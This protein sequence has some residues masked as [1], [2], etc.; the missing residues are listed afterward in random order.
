MTFT[1]SEEVQIAVLHEINPQDAKGQNI[2][3][4]DENTSYGLS[5]ID[6]GQKS[7]SFEFT[8]AALALHSMDSKEFTATVSVDAWI[9]GQPP[10]VIMQKI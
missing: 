7:G 5:L 9:R 1:S 3:T 2:W 8:G 6:V 4:V 10:E